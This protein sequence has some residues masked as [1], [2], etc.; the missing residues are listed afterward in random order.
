MAQYTKA[1]FLAI[2]VMA[3]SG[4]SHAQCGDSIDLG[5]WIQEGVAAYGNWTV[6]GGGTAV[7]QTING[8]PTFYVSPDSFINVII[9]GDIRVNDN[10]DDDWVG[11]VFGYNGPDAVDP[12]NYDFYLFDWKRAGQNFGGFFGNEGFALSRINGPVAS[13]PQTFSSKTGP[14]STILDSQFGNTEGWNSF[15]TYSFALTYTNT[16]TVISIDGD[17]IFDLF[18]CFEPGRFGFYNYSQ[19]NVLYS[20][21]SY[22]VAAAFDVVTPNICLGDTARFIAL[23]DSCFNAAGIPVNNTL[24][25]WD[26]DFGDGN[27]STD[28]NANHYYQSPGTYQVSLVVTDYLNCKDTAYST[29]IVD[30]VGTTLPN[31]TAICFGDTLTLDADTFC[32][33]YLWNTGETS[34][35]INI[36][37]PGTYIVTVSGNFGCADTDSIVLTNIALPVVDIGPDTSICRGDSLT[38]FAGNPWAS[39]LWIGGS[40]QDTLL[41]DTSGIYYVEVT[42]TTTC[43]NSDTIEISYYGHPTVSPP[44]PSYCFG[45]SVTVTASGAVTYNWSPAFGLS[46]TTGTVINI[47]SPVDTVYTIIGLDSNG[48]TD[49]SNFF[50]DVIDLPTVSISPSDSI[51]IGDSTLMYLSLTG[52]AP[53]EV[54]YTLN[55][56]TF[57][58]TGIT[59]NL[60]SFYVSDSGMYTPIYV[61][62]ANCENTGTDSAYLFLHPLPVITFNFANDSICIG[63]AMTIG[64]SGAQNYVWT[65]AIGLNDT[66][67]ATVQANPTATQYYTAEGTTQFG[68]IDTAGI[69]LEVLPLPIIGLNA[70]PNPICQYDTVNLSATGALTYFWTEIATGDTFTATSTFDTPLQPTR[71]HVEGTDVFGCTDTTSI[72]VQVDTLPVVSIAPQDTAFCAGDTG[73]LSAFGA[74]TYLWSP[75]ASLSS[76][77]GNIVNANPADTT[78]YFVTGTDANGCVG[79]DSTYI[80]IWHLPIITVSA[81]SNEMCIFDT[82]QLSATGALTYTWEP[83]YN[84]AQ[85]FDSIALVHPETDTSYVA[86]GTDGFGC[87]GT[88]TFDIVVNPLPNITLNTPIDSICLNDNTAITASGAVSYVW[89]NVPGL[90][91]YSTANT[92]AS[93]NTTTVFEV[94]GTDANGCINNNDTL[95]TV[96]PLPN[97]VAQPANAQICIGESQQLTLPTMYDYVWVPAQDLVF[98]GNNN[99]TVTAN[100]L[101]TTVFT[102]TATDFFGCVSDTTY[103]LAVTPLPVLTLS[104]DVDTLCWSD[105]NT[106][107]IS[108]ANTY[109]WGPNY[110]LLFANTANPKV[111]PATTHT[112]AVTATGDGGCQKDTSIVVPV[113]TVPNYDA[114]PDTSI[115]KG[116]T[117]ELNATGGIQYY[118]TPGTAIS[119]RNIANPLCY[120]QTSRVYSVVITDENGCDFN[121]SFTLGLYNLPIVNAG[122]NDTLCLGEG[123][124]IG[125]A[126]TGPPGATYL[127]SPN[128]TMDNAGLPN[129]SILPIQTTTY[130]VLVTDTN[131]CHKTASVEIVVNPVPAVELLS[132][133][134]YICEG[135]S[136]MVMVTPGLK[137]YQWIPASNVIANTNSSS[138]VYPTA[139]TQYSVVGIDTNGCRNAV[140]FEL[141]VKPLPD[142]NAGSHQEL[143][144]GDTVTVFGTA[145]GVSNRWSPAELV[146]NPDSLL[147]TAYPTIPTNLR[148]TTTDDFG[149][150]N[151]DEVLVFAHPKPLADAGADYENCRMETVYLGGAVT[152]GPE[153]AV[154]WSPVDK[155][156]NPNILNPTV[157]STTKDTFILRVVSPEGCVNT[158][159]V[160]INSDCYIS[161]YAPSAFSPDHDTKNDVFTVY[162]RHLYNVELLI[163]DRFGH[164]IFQTNDLNKGWNGTFNNSGKDAPIGSYYWQCTYES[165]SGRPLSAEGVVSL[166]R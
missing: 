73:F 16:R 15:Q 104:L 59:A 124:R 20:N 37:N 30:S 162:G 69:L 155:V 138:L 152:T 3:I 113:F 156:S 126:P 81:L 51:C 90:S 158:D 98:D 144:E 2:A 116:D 136:G 41:L 4:K 161:F 55:G 70:N 129:P 153:N 82:A 165:E 109:Q 147:T 119:D 22:K 101:D 115:C 148:L 140:D 28:T 72:F 67:L 5:T 163:F 77:T 135:D 46:T 74:Q 88:D 120:S 79:T 114:G 11:F 66:T 7:N 33:N 75:A 99:D 166:I 131:S 87:V 24:V 60:D 84:I 26:W 110:N 142:V 133:P 80:N 112:Y 83:G 43:V 42:D 50:V 32:V 10:G 125:G 38:L 6:T 123:K 146:A 34:Q 40:T 134:D 100:P 57:I 48:C 127:W 160:I 92:S 56:D 149:C 108:G 151:F 17:T 31:D 139:T 49:T 76:T 143:C 102:I 61:A 118:W 54:H 36:T 65:P 12:I 18:G 23:S 53:W 68:C 150:S 14:S 9:R 159:T 8:E 97:I 52:T 91:S 1:F 27:T 93:P 117:I 164:L 19:S 63:E 145:T 132:K 86:F 154:F 25:A 45:D 71:Y 137:T 103:E 96:I 128:A 111:Y 58:R 122:I 47:F 107:S 39:H 157:L 106:I 89:T 64:A 44:N 94:F 21:F 141:E 105:T 62:D 85:T 13:F 35:L 78:L 29:V 130:T 95:I 121:S